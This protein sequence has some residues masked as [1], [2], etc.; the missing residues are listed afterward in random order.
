MI[1]SHKLSVIFLLREIT[2][3][4][5]EYLLLVKKEHLDIQNN[6]V[7]VP[8]INQVYQISNEN[9]WKVILSIYE[10]TPSDQPYLFLSD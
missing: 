10:K 5:I 2:H 6:K 8:A 9:C 4:P 7:I 1:N 3:C